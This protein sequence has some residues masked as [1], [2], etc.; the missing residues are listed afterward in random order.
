MPLPPPNDTT[1]YGGR[2]CNH[3]FFNIACSI[4]AEKNDLTFKYSHE[5]KMKRLGIQ[6]FSGS[7]TYDTLTKLTDSNV[8][9]YI[10]G[11][12]FQTNI[13]VEGFFQIPAYAIFLYDYF[14]TSAIQ[15]SI[16][17]ANK[18]K[19]R[20]G[21]NNDV[22]LHLRLDDVAQYNPGV[23]YFD[24]ALSR[25]SFEKGY[26]SSDSKDHPYVKELIQKWNLILIDADEVETIQFGSTCRHI[27]ISHGSFSFVIGVLGFFGDVYYPP[28][29]YNKWC[30]DI[31]SIPTWHCVD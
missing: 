30:G 19:D 28:K 29:K 5:D 2:F 14:R 23:S 3:F 31:Y 17:E 12:P 7:K 16:M 18:F 20:Y 15:S 26:I 22:F 9:S 21:T 6:L 1:G 8:L 25:I 27:V 10:Q 24:A 13:I 11:E 4:L